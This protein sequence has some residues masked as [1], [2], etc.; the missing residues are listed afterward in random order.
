MRI[1]CLHLPAFPLQ[2]AVL[3][4]PEL[5]GRAV[6][7]L[8]SGS[9]PRVLCASRAAHDLGVRAGM[10]PAQARA[11]VPGL[12]VVEPAEGSWREALLE[13][14]ESLSALSPVVDLGGAGGRDWAGW[15]EV[16]AGQK[17]ERFG[18]AI[19]RQLERA[20]YRA[21][22]G[23]AG[24]RFTAR[25]A[26]LRGDELTIVPRG[27]AAEFLAPL[28]IE[29]LPLAPEVRTMLKAAGVRT[30]G[31]FAALPPPSVERPSSIDYREMARG[32]GPRELTPFGPLRARQP[33][34]VGRQL[35]ISAL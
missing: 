12:A 2:V 30:L 6:A 9:G 26:A 8:G 23:V 31:E 17:S 4:R 18:R 7:V 34:E 16:P 21:R 20:G 35:S 15:L 27:S 5:A 32:N 25:A 13:I 24:D 3:S 28:P 29:L 33:R 14:G 10:A 19:L 11:L 1:A 22:V